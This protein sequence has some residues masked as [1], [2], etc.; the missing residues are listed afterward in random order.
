MEKFLSGCRHLIWFPVIGCIILVLGAVIMGF[1]RI[2]TGF[3]KHFSKMDF[4]AKAGKLLSIKI[5]EIIDLFLVATVAY[6]TAVGLYK[7]FI[8]KDFKLP[9]LL[10]IGNLNEL[11]SKIIGVIVAALAVSFLGQAAEDN[12]TDI[13][14]IGIGIGAVVVSLAV[15]VTLTSGKKK[16]GMVGKEKDS[17]N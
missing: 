11:E 4:S 5:I 13:L 10:K 8:N 1:G 7:L 9:G 3:I 15:F 12:P 6:I 2:I 17:K 16:P 14:N